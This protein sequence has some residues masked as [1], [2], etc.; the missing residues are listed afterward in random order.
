MPPAEARKLLGQDAII[1]AT[2]N[3]L[4]DIKTLAHA[5]IDYIGLGPLHFTGTKKN[6]A[7]VLGIGGVTSILDYMRHNNIAIPVVVI[8]GITPADVPAVIKAGADGV[9]VSDAIA[10]ADDI[11]AAAKNFIDII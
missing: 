9:A 6:L 5:P 4:D 1:G 8:G 3:N 2:A 11:T 10:H 7:D